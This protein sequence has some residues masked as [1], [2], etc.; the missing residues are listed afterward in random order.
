MLPAPFFERNK[1]TLLV[2]FFKTTRT[3]PE[4]VAA[5]VSE[6]TVVVFGPKLQEF[7]AGS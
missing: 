2:L 3:F 4:T 7:L 5:Q 1:D 6:C